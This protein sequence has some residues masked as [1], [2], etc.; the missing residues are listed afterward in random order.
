MAEGPDGALGDIYFD[1]DRFMIRP[2]AKTQLEVNARLL[3]QHNDWKLVL[4]GHCDERGTADYN[5]VLGE[6]RAQSVKKY[7]GDL[8]VPASKLRIVSYGKERPFCSEHSDDCW[9]QNRRVH[10][11][12]Q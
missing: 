7:L 12:M 9:Q 10:F 5:L 2:E 11:V 8:G 3:K 4:E 6:R 1:F